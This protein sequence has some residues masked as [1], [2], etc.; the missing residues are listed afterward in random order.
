MNRSSI[1]GKGRLRRSNY[2]SPGSPIG[3]RLPSVADVPEETASA[4]E[5]PDMDLT[6]QQ[7]AAMQQEERAL[8][9]QIET[10]QKE[11]EELTFE[12]LALEPR[13][14]DDETLESE[15]SIGTA[16]SFENLSMDSEGAVSECSEK[17]LVSSITPHRPEAVNRL[18]RPLRKKADSLESVDLAVH[19]SPTMSSS[20]SC[21][22]QGGRRFRFR[23]KSPSPHTL[24]HTHNIANSPEQRA[25]GD[26]A[27]SQLKVQEERPQFTSRG[28]FNPEKGKQKLKMLKR[29]AQKPKDPTDGT[30]S[31]GKK[32]SAEPD[33]SAHQQVVVFG[34]N[35]FMV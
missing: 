6:E 27:Y 21:L 16:D 12:M 4:D 2:S 32:R 29:S 18:R 8:T 24:Y 28:T 35:E 20:S 3:M 31:L 10:L 23:S 5:S 14:S 15:A 19:S 22:P 7:Q 17:K 25:D 13:A 1:P 9:E 34:N 33:F 26:G 11:K 30:S